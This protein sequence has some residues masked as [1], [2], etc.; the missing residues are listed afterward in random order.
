MK[1]QT[2]LAEFT[3]TASI[4]MTVERTDRNPH[5]EG[6]EGMDNWKCTL[7]HGKRQMTVH[8]SKGIGHHGAEPTIAEVLDCLASDSAGIEGRSFEDFC[9]YYGYD[10]DSRRAERTYKVCVKQAEKFKKFLGDERYHVLLWETE[11]L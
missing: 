2:T 8:F 5:M 11:R 3:A 10:T 4:A 1:T 7:F 6:S 9:E